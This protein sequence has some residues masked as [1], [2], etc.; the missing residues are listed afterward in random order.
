MVNELGAPSRR[1]EQAPRIRRLAS[2]NARGSCAMLPAMLFSG[3]TICTMPG[4]LSAEDASMTLVALEMKLSA[5]GVV[6]PAVHGRLGAG[7]Q[8][9][10]TSGAAAARAAVDLSAVHADIVGDVGDHGTGIA[11]AAGSHGNL[12]AIGDREARCV[13]RD[14]ARAA[15]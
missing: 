2:T 5:A 8:V 3:E 9:N 14:L 15:G 7:A 12:R 4:V 6:R 13:D 1:A 10:R 11:R